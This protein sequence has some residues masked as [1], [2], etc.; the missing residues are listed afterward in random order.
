MSAPGLNPR[1]NDGLG[2]DNDASVWFV[3]CNKS[4]TLVRDV[5]NGGGYAWVEVGGIREISVPLANIAVK[6]KLL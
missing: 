5:W 1:V 3:H 2:G 4:T 6:P